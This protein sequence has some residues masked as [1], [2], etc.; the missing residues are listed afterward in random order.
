MIT[1]ST[2]A[3][4]ST[5]AAPV[6]PWPID[7]DRYD[8]RPELTDREHAALDALDWQV[9]RRRGYDRD[10]VEW[11]VISRL[12]APLDDARAAL[13]WCPDTQAHRRSVTDAVGLVLRRC[14]EDGTSYWAWSAEDW[15]RLIG[16]GH[17]E[18]E[19]AWPG[20]IDGTV[21]PYVAAHAYT[22][23]GFTDFHRIGKFFRRS[24]AWRDVR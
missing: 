2:A 6:W 13:R 15:L 10:R 12:M 23:G 18:F 9:R 11:Q 14:L 24:L 5:A 22:L 16:T 4:S 1:T 8:R 3:V 7:L 20:W 19:N 17:M 21:R